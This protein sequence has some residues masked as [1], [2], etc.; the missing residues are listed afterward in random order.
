M[1]Y[2]LTGHL[3]TI[4]YVNYTGSLGFGESSVRALLGHCGTLDVQDCIATTRHLVKE[5]IAADGPGKQFVFGGSHGG[6][7]AAHRKPAPF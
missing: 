2:V 5:G 3:D 6:F 4:A 7:L 1:F